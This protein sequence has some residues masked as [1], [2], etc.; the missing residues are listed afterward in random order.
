MRSSNIKLRSTNLYLS[1]LDQKHRRLRHGKE[2]HQVQDRYSRAEPHDCWEGQQVSSHVDHQVTQVLGE[3]EE[4]AERAA[5][6]V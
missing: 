6:V 1:L 2:C 4:G 3:D 5:H